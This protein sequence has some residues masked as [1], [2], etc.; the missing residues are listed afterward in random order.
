MESVEMVAHL[1]VLRCGGDPKKL[2]EELEKHQGDKIFYEQMI[3]FLKE[4]NEP[5]EDARQ[6]LIEANACIDEILDVLRKMRKQR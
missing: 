6:A 5:L 4:H 3:V 1:A 2:R